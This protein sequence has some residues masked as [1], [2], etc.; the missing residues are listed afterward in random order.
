MKKS[1]NY[2]G[3]WNVFIRFSHN[4]KHCFI[5]TTISVTQENINSKYEITELNIQRKCNRII[6]TY[7]KAVA[8]LHLDS[9][10][11]P[12]DRIVEYL[13]NNQS[14]ENIDFV[15]FANKWCQE[16]S[17]IKGIKNYK[18]SI[19]ALC[20]FYGKSEIMINEITRKNL[21]RFEESLREKPRAQTLY[22]FSIKRLFQAAV[23][24]YND[25]DYNI[26]I[27]R[28]RLAK[29]IPPRQRTT[30][31]R[32]LSKDDVR[33]IF[34]VPYD[35]LSSHGYSSRHDLAK[36]CFMLSFCL[37]GMNSADMYSAKKYDGKYI[38]Y[39]RVKTRDRRFDRAEIKVKVPDV[40]SHLIEKYKGT[41]T[42]FNFSERYGSMANFNRAINL[43]LKSIGEEL[44]IPNLQ[45]YS[46]RHSMASISFNKVG[47]DKYTIND[48]LNHI[49]SE[50]KI[51]DIYIEKDYNRINDA[52]LKLMNYMFC[53]GEKRKKKI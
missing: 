39:E 6:E 29:Y 15:A 22:T 33:A 17:Y 37:L 47:I 48:M 40:I 16:H 38:T 19:Q 28:D 25:E 23:D 34:S 21:K 8:N 41:N 50:M 27:I 9:C 12:I 10:S 46:A 24:Y 44:G 51:T 45:F 26:Y 49:D 31:K 1:K 30:K 2:D 7:R 13:Q 36:D 18:T 42:V 3:T 14:E 32:T 43:G 4:K 11:I 35:N 52:N 20:R 53:S 5:P